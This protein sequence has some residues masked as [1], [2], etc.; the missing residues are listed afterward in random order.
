MT[1]LDFMQNITAPFTP[2]PDVNE[3]FKELEALH[4]ENLCNKKYCPYCENEK[5]NK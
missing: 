3:I 2:K 5:T 1:F 4:K